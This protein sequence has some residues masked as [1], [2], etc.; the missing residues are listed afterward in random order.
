MKYTICIKVNIRLQRGT[1]NIFENSSQ[2]P[3]NS[4]SQRWLTLSGFYIL[5]REGDYNIKFCRKL[6]RKL[7]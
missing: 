7:L 6:I 2:G 5:G 3:G 4:Y 1:D